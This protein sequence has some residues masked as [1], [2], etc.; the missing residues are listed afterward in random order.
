MITYWFVNLGVETLVL[1]MALLVLAGSQ[2]ERTYGTVG[3]LAVFVPSLLTAALV[4]LL[5]EP[6]HAFNAGTSGAALGVGAAA[7]INHRRGAPLHRTF[8]A[9]ITPCC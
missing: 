3:F 4:A 9:P 1:V 6:A 5:I 2:I 8:L 7:I